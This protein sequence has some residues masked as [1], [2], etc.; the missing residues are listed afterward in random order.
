MYQFKVSIRS[1]S[2]LI[3]I[4]IGLINSSALAQPSAGSLMQQ[5][6]SEQPLMVLPPAKP[7]VAPEKLA[8]TDPGQQQVLIRQFKF[9]GNQKLSEA[10]LQSLVAPYK[11]TSMSFA[12]IKGLTELIGEYYRQKGWLA[13]ALVPAQ[14]VTDGTLTIQVVEAVVGGVRI[15][16]QSKRVSTERVESWIGS[17]LPQD[18]GLSLDKLDRA[19]LTLNDLPDVNV[20]S[21]LQRGTKEGE[22]DL[23]VL[24]TDKPRADGFLDVDNFGD[25]STGIWRAVGNVYINSPL[26]FGDQA[27]VYGLYSEGVTFG[28]LSY[29][30]PV[31]QDGL[32]LGVNASALNYRVTNRSWD[33]L[34]LGGQSQSGGLEASYP[35]LRSRPA[36]LYA[37]GFYNYSNYEN[38]S[39][40]NIT[41]R[42][43]TS[44]LSAGISGNLMDGLG[45]GGTST[46]ALIFSAGDVI[47]NGSPLQSFNEETINTGGKFTKI[48]YSL[49]RLQNITSDISGYVALSGQLANKNMD[50]SE[51]MFMGGP[52]AVRAYAPGQGAAT[53]GNLLTAELRFRLPHQFLVTAF[54]DLANV[55][56][57]KYSDYPGN[58]GANS[59]LLQGLGLSLTWNAPKNILV[60]ATWAHRTGG[61]SDAAQ[62]YLTNNGGL[63]PNRFWL[64]ASIS[65]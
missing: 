40:G 24:V 45:G 63:S 2:V 16:N 44:V 9:T 50:S 61:L 15:D 42:Y 11:N 29:T 47:L 54:Y 49:N 12:E 35:I 43:K 30:V 8:P 19:M 46:G 31:G 48:R 3:F 7:G 10:D 64:N 23:N 6:Q 62:T 36:N 18:S 53:Q 39:D 27:I 58:T 41:N 13:R 59:Y 33:D 25:P 17:H 1:Y 28:R 34:R 65:F 21:S 14:D 26:G 57:L 52:Y 20:V 38:R 56:S 5:L 51:Q 22:T 32:R 55:Q 4:F 60:R 37:I